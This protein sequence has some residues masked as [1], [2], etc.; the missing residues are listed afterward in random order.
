MYEGAGGTSQ[1]YVGGFSALLLDTFT[2]KY[3]LLRLARKTFFMQKNIG[4]RSVVYCLTGLSQQTYY[5][6]AMVAFVQWLSI[7]NFAFQLL[8]RDVPR[9]QAYVNTPSKYNIKV[10]SNG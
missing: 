8:S 7:F 9:T 4:F 10:V 6:N 2:K 3:P 1:Q 5:P